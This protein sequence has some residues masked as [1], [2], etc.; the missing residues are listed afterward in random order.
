[1]KT[2]RMTVAALVTVIALSLQTQAQTT[3]SEGNA[4][5]TAQSKTGTGTA[6]QPNSGQNRAKIERK[7]TGSRPEVNSASDKSDRYRTDNMPNRE[8]RSTVS[9]D[10][11]GRK[12]VGGVRPKAD[13]KT[14]KKRGEGRSFGN[15]GPN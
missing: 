15:T 6:Q 10:A 8:K 7:V 11:D 4:A 14:K 5:N 9:S 13:P 1:M 2:I 12:S 3:S